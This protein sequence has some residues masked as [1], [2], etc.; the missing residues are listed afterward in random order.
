M[1]KATVKQYRVARTDESFCFV[2]ATSKKEAIELSN[3]P[4][5]SWNVWIGDTEAE[6]VKG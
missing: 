2:D 6:E 1:S 3:E 4:D 5:A